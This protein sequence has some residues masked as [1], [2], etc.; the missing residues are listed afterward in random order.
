[1]V[2]IEQKKE[3][4]ELNKFFE[5]SKSRFNVFR[6]KNFIK[7]KTNRE[8]HLDILIKIGKFAK[9]HANKF[10][11]DTMWAYWIVAFRNEYPEFNALW[12]KKKY[13]GTNVE[14]LGRL[15]DRNRETPKRDDKSVV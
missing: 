2:N 4:L 8:P 3:L 13:E 9:R 12:E 10:S 5:N 7:F 14:L 11:Q 15:F 6:F 1:M